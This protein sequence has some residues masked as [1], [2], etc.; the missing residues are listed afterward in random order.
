MRNALLRRRR[1]CHI[2]GPLVSG[3][4]LVEIIFRYPGM[5]PCLYRAVTGFDYFAFMPWSTSL[6]SASVCDAVLDIVYPL[7][8]PGFAISGPDRAMAVTP[9]R[10][11]GRR[12]APDQSRVRSVLGYLNANPQL[13]LGFDDRRA[14]LVLEPRSVL[15]DV[16]TAGRYPPS[17][18]W[19]HV[20]YPLG[21]DTPVATS[22]RHDRRTPINAADR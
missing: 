14:G 22:W 9:P 17:R 6:S 12:Q 10:H 7:L 5:V 13:V 1:L 16:K 2:A 21:T 20:Q 4:L 3:A 18:S 8:D 11:A 19:S 15:V